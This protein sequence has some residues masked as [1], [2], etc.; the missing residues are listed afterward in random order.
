VPLELTLTLPLRWRDIDPLG[1]L[2]QAVY[3]ELLE[4]ARAGLVTELVARTGAE[5]VHGGF[6]VRHV[7]LDYLHEVRRDAGTVDVTAR[8]A[9]VGTSSLTLEHEVRLPDG[10]LAASGHAVLVG[11]DPVTRGKRPLGEVERAALGG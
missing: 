7:D 5:H 9:A 3:H 10:T 4:E 1:H 11:W 8:V 2:N 6:I